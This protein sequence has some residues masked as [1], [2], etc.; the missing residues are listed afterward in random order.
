MTVI[1]QDGFW[2]QPPDK[3]PEGNFPGRKLSPNCSVQSFQLLLLKHTPL[4]TV[5]KKIRQ[6]VIQGSMRPGD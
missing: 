5:R 6:S 3:R 4:N 1:P 2:K